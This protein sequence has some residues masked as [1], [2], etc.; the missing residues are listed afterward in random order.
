[1]ALLGLFSEVNSC[2]LLDDLSISW[3]VVWLVNWQNHAEA[4][5]LGRKHWKTFLNIWLG[6]YSVSRK[7]QSLVIYYTWACW[8]NIC[9]TTESSHIWSLNDEIRLLWWITGQAEPGSTNQQ[10]TLDPCSVLVQLGCTA[11]RMYRILQD[12]FQ[13]CQSCQRF[14][15][16]GVT[17]F[18]GAKHS[19]NLNLCIAVVDG[20][21]SRI[22][23]VRKISGDAML[24]KFGN[25]LYHVTHCTTPSGPWMLRSNATGV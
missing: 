15:M 14:A 6:C 23:E 4:C 8:Y 19:E 18:M 10:Q 13:P 12:S 9:C 17:Q 21:M 5:E 7:F 22:Q 16:A 1:M 2:E 24:T 20:L 25:P 11:D 3:V